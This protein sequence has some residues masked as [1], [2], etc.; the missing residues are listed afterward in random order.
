MAVTHQ[1]CIHHS[2]HVGSCV[3]LYHLVV[4]ATAGKMMIESDLLLSMISILDTPSTYYHACRYECGSAC[5]CRHVHE[6]GVGSVG[7][8]ECRFTKHINTSLLIDSNYYLIH[9]NYL[10]SRKKGYSGL[11]AGGTMMRKLDWADI[12][13][14]IHIV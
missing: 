3:G 5:S 4:K 1:V 8:S 6:P 11:I 13:D 10:F 14:I 7:D 9:F 2:I 12:N